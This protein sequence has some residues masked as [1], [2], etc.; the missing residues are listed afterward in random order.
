MT[1][2]EYSDSTTDEFT[3]DG[4]S[5]LLSATKGRHEITVN[6]T[7][8]DDGA[9]VSESYVLDG[10]TYTLARTYDADN[11]VTSQTFADGKVMTWDYDVRHLVTQAHYDGD[12]VLEQDYDPGYRLTR[13]EYGNDLVREITFNR[14]DNLRTADKVKDG[15]TTIDELDFGYTYLADKNV[16]KETQANGTFEKLSFTAAYD[17]GN[18]VTSYN[19][20]D[21]YLGARIMQ[22]WAYDGAGNW[23]STVIDGDTQNRTHSASDQLEVIAGDNLTYDSKGNQLTDNRD[24]EYEW[25]LDNRI[26]KSEGSGYSDIE[27]R[28]DALGRRIVRKQGSD[29]EVLLW[30]GNTEQSEHKHQ[31][32]Q[33]TIQNDLQANPSEN[34]LNTVFARALEGS[35]FEIQ[36][37][38]K[39]YLDHVMAVSNDNGNLIEHYRYTAFGEPEIYAPNGTRLTTTAIDND[40]LWNVRRYEASNGLYMYLYRDYDA[41]SGRWPSRDP[42][43]EE[44]GVNLYGFVENNSLNIIDYLGEIGGIISVDGWES[45]YDA[46]GTFAIRARYCCPKDDIPEGF[47][48]VGSIATEVKPVDP[49]EDLVIPIEDGKMYEVNGYANGR[50]TGNATV[51]YKLTYAFKDYNIAYSKW[52]MG[53]GAAKS[54]A[55]LIAQAKARKAAEEEAFRAGTIN[56]PETCILLSKEIDTKGVF[57]LLVFAEIYTIPVIKYK[58]I[59]M[60]LP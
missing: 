44:G 50:G 2:R 28:Y 36:Y 10:R 1:S 8:A 19:R 24:N 41:A 20:D 57:G 30:W 18:R 4:A 51:Y 46:V 22:S 14:A 16:E 42:V 34:A 59:Q 52:I 29:K 6:R 35:R 23:D 17:A 55:R 7:Y 56:V 15:L 60:E 37:F 53:S 40:I 47:T 13:Q 3:Y 33:T 48:D 32:G 9:M 43:G 58:E 45:E 39:N 54:L 26:V 11:R 31:A 38:H 12:L 27:Y 5:R 49:D 21:T 25:D